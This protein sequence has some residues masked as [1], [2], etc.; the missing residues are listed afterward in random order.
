MITLKSLA[1]NFLFI[2]VLMFDLDILG[3]ISGNIQI[4]LSVPVS[5]GIMISTKGLSISATLDLQKNEF[6]QPYLRVAGCELRGGFY[7]AKVTDLGLLT[8]SIN[9][10]YRQEMIG[11]ARDVIQTTICSNLDAIVKSQV[12]MR[13]TE[14]P[15][16][17]S[18]GKIMEFL[19]GEAPEEVR[20]VS[21]HNEEP[22]FLPVPLAYNYNSQPTR[23]NQQGRYGQQ[24]FYYYYQGRQKRSP[25][26][27][28]SSGVATIT[29]I[30]RS[31]K[32]GPKEK[33]NDED[34]DLWSHA[35]SEDGNT[36]NQPSRLKEISNVSENKS[37]PVPPSISRP[38]KPSTS[39]PPRHEISELD[40]QNSK[41]ALDPSFSKLLTLL[42]LD[43][44]HRLF[45]DLDFIDSFAGSDFFS[46]GISGMGFVKSA[47]RELP[48]PP[49]EDQPRKLKFPGRIRKRNLDLIISDFTP[50]TLLHQ[51]HKANLLKMSIKA[52][53]PTFGKLLRTTCSPD[54]V[55]LSDSVSEVS[56]H[57]PN[58]QLEAL[59]ETIRAPEVKIKK[60]VMEISIVGLSTFYLADTR[61]TIGKIP[62]S[63]V[64][65]VG[66]KTRGTLLQVS[67][68][69]R[70]LRILED[71]D[72]F[73]I[74]ADSLNGF[75]DAIKGTVENLARQLLANGIDFHKFSR[76]FSEYGLSNFTLELLEE[77]IILIQ[78]DVDVFKLAFD[79]GGE[80]IGK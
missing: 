34:Y 14:I 28:K 31:A 80:G 5:G 13:L 53:T 52:N 71:L 37:F 69:L 26:G 12:N 21:V 68:K 76:R 63:T 51:A 62:F 50:N 56:E 70:D 25:R 19:D 9:M 36:S 49:S 10:K 74:P 30:T 77:E 60:D 24:Q 41:A 15:H 7:D 42:N 11:K 47:R 59:I 16:S 22:R 79:S 8:E 3:T 35:D 17:V 40:S 27:A 39:L 18:V 55:C 45:V 46:V 54:E 66:I 78:A 6:R 1:P 29:E 48:Y 75:R 20:T 67:L 23:Y 32:P 33:D 64:V 72:F 57:Y 4:V 65:E 43:D 44:L 58:R 73:D 2:N 38:R 61:Q